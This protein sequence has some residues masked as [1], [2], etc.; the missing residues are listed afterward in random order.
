MINKARKQ[1]AVIVG[2]TSKWQSDGRNTKL[3]HGASI[4]DSELPPGVRW[5]VGGAISLKFAAEGF[6][7]VLPTRVEVTAAP[8][9]RAARMAATVA[10][11][12][13]AI[14]P[15]SPGA[16]YLDAHGVERAD[17]N[18]YG[19]RRGNHETMMRG[20]FANIR[21]RNE[22]VPGVEG[23]LTRHLP[24]GEQMTIYEAAMQYI[25]EGVPSIL[26]GGKEYGSG[27]S[28]DWAAKGPFLQGV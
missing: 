4:D 6:F 25:A 21:I 15:G 3:A 19:S 14:A 16:Q 2:A 23:G 12:A 24:S 13:G 1:V 5:G 7:T 11:M 28:R 10:A 26:L 8:L 9:A 22:L 17:W 27:S 18:S 20:T